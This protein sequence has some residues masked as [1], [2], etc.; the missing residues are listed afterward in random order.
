MAIVAHLRLCDTLSVYHANRVSACAF[1]N[2]PSPLLLSETLQY[3]SHHFTSFRVF[4]ACRH[5]V[6]TS[7]DRL[8][9]AIYRP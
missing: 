2:R 6:S 1:R 4:Y 7:P 5:A 8:S 9:N 3:P